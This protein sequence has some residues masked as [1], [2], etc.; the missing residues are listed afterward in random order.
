MAVDLLQTV[1]RL[2][3]ECVRPRDF[4]SL[5][6]LTLARRIAP[7]SCRFVYISSLSGEDCELPVSTEDQVSE[8]V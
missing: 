2:V 4:D 1:F 3:K 8:V 7:P 5:L 6:F